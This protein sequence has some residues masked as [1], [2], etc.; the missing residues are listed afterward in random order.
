[1]IVI[2]LILLGWCLFWIAILVS[3]GKHYNGRWP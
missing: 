2:G 3:A 1:M